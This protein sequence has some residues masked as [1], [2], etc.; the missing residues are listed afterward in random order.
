MA[1]LIDRY[2]QDP[3]LVLQ[4]LSRPDLML[5]HRSAALGVSPQ[6]VR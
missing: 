4:A 3:A 1:E 6:G 5:T 2:Q